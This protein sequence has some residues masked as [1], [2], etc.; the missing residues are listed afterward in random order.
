M[1]AT[2]KAISDVVIE[3]VDLTKDYEVGF[4]IK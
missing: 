3:I 4:L 1:T 2:T